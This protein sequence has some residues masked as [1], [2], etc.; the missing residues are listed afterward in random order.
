MKH[1]TNAHFDKEL[2]EALCSLPEDVLRVSK[3]KLDTLWQ[4][5]CSL[6]EKILEHP[7]RFMYNPVSKLGQDDLYLLGIHPG[8]DPKGNP[9][10]EKQSL[11]GEIR[12]WS[13]KST[14]AMVSE[15]WSGPYYQSTIR[16]LCDGIGKELNELC[17]SNLYFVRAQNYDTLLETLK[18][19]ELDSNGEDF[20]LVHKEVI[21]IIQPKC[22]LVI[23]IVIFKIILQL[24]R[25][26]KE[27][28]KPSLRSDCGKYLCSVFAGQW[29]G[30]PLTLIGI[31][32]PKHDNQQTHLMNYPEVLEK[33]AKVVRD[34]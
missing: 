30:Q 2:Y 29:Q 33:I 15:N 18:N 34:V 25:F 10:T 4:R 32:Y 14:N 6:P 11:R 26:R 8:I 7:G 28:E 22:I 17:A 24:L 20:W 27:W 3:E 16:T 21:G 9:K 31:P 5:L 23:G 13:K 1:E 19:M 12:E